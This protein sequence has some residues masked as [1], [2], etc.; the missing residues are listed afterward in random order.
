MNILII[1]D[2][3]SIREILTDILEDEGYKVF[4]SE[5]GESGIRWL[6][7]EHIDM[8][9]LDI[10]MP[11]LGGIDVLGTIKERFPEV[12]V[13][14][15]SGH[16][17]IDQAVRATK[18]GA[19][20]FLEKPLTIESVL[21]IVK[22]IENVKETIKSMPVKIVKYDEMIGV[23]KKML[24]IKHLVASAAK[25]DARVLIFGENGAGKE[26]V[27][28]EV[29]NQSLR[30]NK[31]FISVNCA[32]IPE[33]LI[34]SELFGHVKGAFTGAIADS[35]GRF[36]QAD[37]GTLFL[38]EVADM[39]LAMQAKL[40]RVLQEMKLTRVGGNGVIDVDIRIIAATNKDVKAE[41]RKG[42]FREDL[43]YRLNV[44]PIQVP[45]LRERRE[46]I[47]IL[48]DYFNKKLSQNNNMVPK[49]FSSDALKYL[50]EYNWPGN[51]RQLRN[52]VERLLVMSDGGS[53]GIMDIKKYVEMDN[54][55]E[56]ETNFISKYDDC[57]LNDARIK[58]ERDFIQ[59]KLKE[60]GF[61]LSQ[62]AR[63]LG[64]F[65]SNLSVKLM[66]L[67]LKVEELRG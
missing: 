52:I 13:V 1:D 42:L 43:Y 21:S 46:D 32:A 40:L 57:E 25:S 3:E 62:T 51:I 29:H 26:L 61:N 58:F 14:M 55:T 54:R 28:R 37:R 56:D 64:I 65:P 39:S 50:S 34:E 23:S 35:A 4:S 45:P 41:I 47:P 19:Y 59:K 6:D 11:K 67:G 12:E 17:K 44:I 2:E 33:N 18:M 9:F 48:I 66:K 7:R 5:D 8:C 24:E 63:A 30:K 60:N 53:I 31:Q 10:W 36:E 16:A 22:N 20:D 27:A 15:I 38:D 49:E